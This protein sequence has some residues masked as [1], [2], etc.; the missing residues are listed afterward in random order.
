MTAI[1]LD[2]HPA[3][4]WFVPQVSHIR[5]DIRRW[6]TRVPQWVDNVAKGKEDRRETLIHAEFVEG[7]TIG[8]ARSSG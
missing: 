1:A 4:E 7:G 5:T 6:V 8:P 3:F 2:D